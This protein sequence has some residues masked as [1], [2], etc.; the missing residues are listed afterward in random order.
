[1]EIKD[2]KI[3]QK[4]DFLVNNGCRR[5]ISNIE[6]EGIENNDT[7]VLSYKLTRNPDEK[8]THRYKTEDVVTI[9]EP[10]PIWQKRNLFVGHR[11]NVLD[12]LLLPCRFIKESN[13]T[14]TVQIARKGELMNIIFNKSTMTERGAGL[15]YHYYLEYCKTPE[16]VAEYNA[17]ARLSNF[18]KVIPHK[19]C[20]KLNF[21]DVSDED[22]KK[23]WEILK[24]YCDKQGV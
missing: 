18:R 2:L 1:M 17:K 16:E 6:F 10:T 20:Q 15:F 12:N 9:E 14:F 24:P 11:G 8:V 19:I 3:G 21:D 23:V 4:Y 5:W 7:L 13:T 22:L